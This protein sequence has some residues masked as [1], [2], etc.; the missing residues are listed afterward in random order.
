MSRIAGV[1]LFALSAIV[2]PAEAPAQVAV[3]PQAEELT[4]ARAPGVLAGTLLVP[5]SS[6]P[7]PLVLLVAGSG[8]T[9]RDGNSSIG[10]LRPNSLRQIAESLASFG[11]ASLRFDKRGVGGSRSS[12]PLAMTTVGD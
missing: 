6:Q 3:A 8:P 11:I 1:A 10:Q 2:L 9:D 7:R 12:A 4:I 5:A